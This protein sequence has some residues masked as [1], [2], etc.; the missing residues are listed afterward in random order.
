MRCLALIRRLESLGTTAAEKK[1]DADGVGPALTLKSDVS[2][3][4]DIAIRDDFRKAHLS[5]RRSQA[6]IHL[7]Q[8]VL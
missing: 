1:R 4:Y 5:T 6:Y 3:H 8:G 7:H 2:L